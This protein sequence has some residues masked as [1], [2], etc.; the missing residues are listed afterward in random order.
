MVP[1]N[2]A[3]SQFEVRQDDQL[4]VL[5]YDRSG[6]RLLL[7]H[8]E[9]PQARA[10]HGIGGALAQAALKYARAQRQLDVPHCPYVRH[11]LTQH[12]QEMALID[13]TAGR[14]YCCICRSPRCHYSQVIRAEDREVSDSSVAQTL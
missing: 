14:A 11:Y 6:E 4:A 7:L 10:G 1:Y 13:P 5:Q 2:F 9:V 12:P 8:T 3:A